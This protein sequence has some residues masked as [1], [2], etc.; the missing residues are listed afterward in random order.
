MELLHNGVSGILTFFFKSKFTRV[1]KGQFKMSK[2]D[3]PRI[4]L[5]KNAKP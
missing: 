4:E 1:K 5:E 3:S 2:I